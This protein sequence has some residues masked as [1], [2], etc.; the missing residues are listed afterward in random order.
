MSIPVFILLSLTLTPL[1]ILGVLLMFKRH[2][3]PRTTRHI[4]FGRSVTIHHCEK[5]NGT[6]CATDWSDN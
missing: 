2:P 5:R 3:N 1:V 6:T 4:M